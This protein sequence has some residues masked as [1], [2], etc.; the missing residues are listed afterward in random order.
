[1]TAI[2]KAHQKHTEGSATVSRRS[3]L[4]FMSAGAAGF[5]LGLFNMPAG[6]SVPETKFSPNAFLEIHADNSV[7]FWCKR[8]EL[9]QLVKTG[10]AVLVADELGAELSLLQM[11][12]TTADEKY[13]YVG[14]GGS[15]A[16]LGA[17]R[18]YRPMFA[19]AREMLITAA[20]NQWGVSAGSCI[21]E[22]GFI[23]DKATGRKLPFSVLLDA[24]GKLPVPEKPALKDI[25]AFKY[26]GKA[27]GRLDAAEIIS[28]SA[29][30]GAD[31]VFSGLKYASIERCPVRGGTLLSVDTAAALNTAGVVD[32]LT[33][34]NK[35]A[36]VATNSWAA[37]QARK[38]LKVEWSYGE[39]QGISSSDFDRELT[40][41]LS[42]PGYLI[43][44][45]GTAAARA[46]TLEWVYEISAASH[47]P[48]ETA[49]AT[50]QYK[51]GV[52][53]VWSPCHQQTLA[54]EELA[55]STGLP[56]EK[57]IINTTLAGGSFGRKLARDYVSEVADIALRVAYPVQL[58]F[59]RE[60]DCQH[61]PHRPPTKHK[62]SFGLD[63]TDNPTSCLFHM[64]GYSV[65]AQEGPGGISEK[66]FDWTAALGAN[67]I[68]YSF[69]HIRISHKMHE[70]SALFFTWWRGT[71][72]NHNCFALECAMDELA[73]ETDKDP[74]ELRLQFLS[75]D[76]TAETFPGDMET[77]SSDRMKNT[78]QL[79]AEKAD[80][81]EQR[82]TGQAVGIACHCYTDVN[83]YSAFA[84]DVSV[85]DGQVTVHKVTVVIDCGFAVNPSAVRAQVEGGIVFGL[86]GAIAQE[87][88]IENG[89]VQ[90]VNFDSSP[91]LRMADCP[92]IEV[93][94]V[95]SLAEPG[96]VG[97]P[98][99]TPLMPAFINAVSRAEGRRIRRLPLGGQLSG[100]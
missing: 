62:V 70:T 13:G 15:G 17:W 9:G 38:A 87:T 99:L 91:V 34:G 100:V 82:P 60:D 23:A 44:E 90:Q 73:I 37:M 8:T 71:Y 43:R 24:A 58:L 29:I 32:V 69:N 77:V 36:V 56:K 53:T 49:T 66:G 86:S 39:N 65:A 11:H 54:A 46:K 48:L 95:K 14:T 27:R 5:G 51:G 28:G 7:H 80:F 67:D 6:A 20:A 88:T 83:S 10:I 33:I 55:K 57:V 92:A 72:R 89:Q 76:I 47:A 81:Y 40:E 94:I 30:Y 45:T 1:M 79:L 85:I 26:T 25:S 21:A 42:E 93:H 97:E 61:G 78:L 41:G 64:S 84:V 4:K 22:G 59:T 75:N 98:A 12:Q 63:E 16:T 74:L 31:V 35:V 68:P 50:A 18:Y 19:A 96:G 3:I 2:Q 52:L